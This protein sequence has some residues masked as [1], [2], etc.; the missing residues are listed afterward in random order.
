[1]QDSNLASLNAVRVFVVVA[2]R[3]S[4]S[5]AAGDLCVTPSAVSHQIKKL[6]ADLGVA[7]FERTNNRI[8]L[9]EAGSRFLEEVAPA[10]SILERSIRSMHRDAD[11]IVLRVSTTFAVRRLIPALHR[12]R[13]SRPDARVRIETDTDIDVPIGPY[14]DAAICYR[15]P[16]NRDMEGKVLI[17]DRSVP[18]VSPVLLKRSNY[19]SVRDV[20]SIPALQCTA[21]NWDW[22]H[23]AQSTGID[24][25]ALR[26]ENAFDT[27]DAALHAAAAGL[28]MVLSPLFMIREALASGMLIAVPGF[29]PVEFGRYHF[30]SNTYE[31]PIVR[32]L[33]SWLQKELL[34]EG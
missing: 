33:R 24:F 4:I 31:R 18:V 6:E 8:G 7:L 19:R 12:F 15:R 22:R 16:A 23:W 13:D 26:I 11:E 17:V 9:T 21:D 28:G 5:L 34:A 10:I 14:A 2:Q 30:V 25:G 3:R 1:M 27:D 32:R 29:S 20:G